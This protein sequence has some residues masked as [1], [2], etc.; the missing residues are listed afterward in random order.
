MCLLR[1]AILQNGMTL[2]V[3]IAL[4]GGTCAVIQ[5][6]RCVFIPDESAGVSSL[7]NHMRTQVYT[8][9]DPVPSPGDPLNE[10][11][12]SWG[13]WWHI[14]TYFRNHYDNLCFFLH[15]PVLLLEYPLPVQPDHCAEWTSSMLMKPLSDP[16]GT[17]EAGSIWDCKSLSPGV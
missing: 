6:K 11:F 7:L 10:W 17:M 2:D 13:T 15:L 9:S 14:V 4:R 3:I 8:L 1:K 12:R 5:I 16:Q